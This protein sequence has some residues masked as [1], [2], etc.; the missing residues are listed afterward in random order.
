MEGAVARLIVTLCAVAIELAPVAK[1]RAAP[2]FKIDII[3]LSSLFDGPPASPSTNHRWAAR[4]ARMRGEYNDGCSAVSISRTRMV[5][6]RSGT[7][8]R[9]Y[10]EK[11]RAE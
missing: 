7:R 5:R 11:R 10:R 8:R 1:A 3:K 6:A 2:N 4:N 9:R